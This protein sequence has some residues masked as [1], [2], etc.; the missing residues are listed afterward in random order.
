MAAI[1]RGCPICCRQLAEVESIAA[2][3]TGQQKPVPEPRVSP[4]ARPPEPQ[5][6]ASPFA[7]A[8]AVKAGGVA[9]ALQ[10][11]HVVHV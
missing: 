9:G 11:L 1:R 4:L 7:A 10:P 3:A 6:A 2:E 8:S 5:P